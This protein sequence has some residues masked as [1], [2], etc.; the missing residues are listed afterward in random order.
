MLSGGPF[1]IK[2]L[3]FTAIRCRLQAFASETAAPQQVNTHYRRQRARQHD[4]S[5][6]SACPFT[7][8]RTASDNLPVYVIK[9]KN[10]PWA[11]LSEMF[12]Q[13]YCHPICPHLY[14]F[15]DVLTKGSM[16]FHAATNLQ[17]ETK[18][19]QWSKRSVEIQ[20]L[21]GRRSS[22]C[23]R[24]VPAT[25]RVASC[26]SL[27]ITGGSSRVTCKASATEAQKDKK[28]WDVAFFVWWSWGKGSSGMLKTLIFEIC[29]GF[30]GGCSC[31]SEGCGFIAVASQCAKGSNGPHSITHWPIGILFSQLLPN[32]Q[33]PSTCFFFGRGV[34]MQAGVPTLNRR[35]AWFG[36]IGP[37]APAAYQKDCKWIHVNLLCQTLKWLAGVRVAPKLGD[38]HWLPHCHQHIPAPKLQ[39]KIP[40]NA[41]AYSYQSNSP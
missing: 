15:L 1:A 37:G 21:S 39:V 19:S 2:R 38:L 17:Q 6:K 35:T 30:T 32:H 28:C 33:N 16:Y 29:Y 25:E 8:H 26:R 3:S 23:V 24:R 9:R 7:V 27:G 5:Y 40:L 22:S 20:K 10:R 13:F 34:S 36:W 41:G 11:L 12:H 31:P 18:T 14:A 4:R